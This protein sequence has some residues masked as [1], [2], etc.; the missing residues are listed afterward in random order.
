MPNFHASEFRRLTL[1]PLGLASNSDVNAVAHG[2]KDTFM[3]VLI[4]N[5]GGAMAFFGTASES[6]IGPD[7]PGTDVFEIPPDKEDVFVLAPGQA[8]YG[9][10]NGAGLTISIS[11]SQAYPV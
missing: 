11:T 6:M 7:A 4:R 10:A 5:N 2:Y 9:C 8:L 1:P 3:R